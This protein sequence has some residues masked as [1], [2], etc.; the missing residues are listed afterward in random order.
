MAL[1]FAMAHWETPPAIFQ[2]ATSSAWRSART[3]ASAK[4]IVVA[5]PTRGV[6]IAGSAFIHN[7]I[8]AFRD[9]GGAVLL[10]SEL[11]DE[12]LAISDRIVC[13]FVN[14]QIIGEL[15]RSEASVETVGRMM[16]GKKAAA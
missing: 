12:I 2:A 4:N 7:L 14:G 8:V 13:L 9:G 1:A 16:L 5:Q 11:L 3:F 10:V 15:S 6:D